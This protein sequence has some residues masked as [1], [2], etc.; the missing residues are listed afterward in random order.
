ME[1][2][3]LE[4][5]YVDSGSCK[6]LTVPKMEAC[7]AERLTSRTLDVEVQASPVALFP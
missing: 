7:V 3:S 5:L 1:I 2:N 6:G 4:N